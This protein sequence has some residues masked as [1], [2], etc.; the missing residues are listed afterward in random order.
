MDAHGDPTFDDLLEAAERI[1]GLVH[2]TPLV[3]CAA[4]D[5]ATG[6]RVLLK[7]ENLQKVGA[8]KARGATNA[9]RS[10]RADV[11]ARGV[12]THSSGNHAQALAW[13]AGARGI[14]AFIVMPSTA[15]AVKRAAVAAYGAR[16]TECEPTLEAR[17]ASLAKV[18]AATGAV[19]VHPYDDPR[20]IAGQGTAALEA[21]SD[22]PDA[23]VV[24]VPV[25]GGGLAS[26]SCLAASG[27]RPDLEVW[28]AEPAGADDAF[29]SLRDGRR[30]PSVD[31]RTC[32]DGLLTALSDRTFRI[33][34][35]RITGI[36]TVSET[37]IAHAMRLLFERAKLVVEPSGAVPLA[38]LLEHPDR[39]SNRTVVVVLSGGNVDPK[40]LAG[41]LA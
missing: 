16:I 8:F 7:C 24:L 15:P 41:L 37:S 36:L 17:E 2:R 13:A 10:L 14:P 9:V 25:G 19:F 29:R 34:Q 35:R 3:T 12:C 38:V 40:R 33:L 18:Q 23:D 31:P 21:L 26:G 39:F 32:A 22:T 1:H 6:A 11:A 30:H 5:D 20:V 4:V 27:L 28:G